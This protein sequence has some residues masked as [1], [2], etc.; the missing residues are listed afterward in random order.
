M[1]A[2]ARMGRRRLFLLLQQL[3]SAGSLLRA[4]D[5]SPERTRFSDDGARAASPTTVGQSPGHV[6]AN[7]LQVPGTPSGALSD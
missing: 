1:V 2:K 6:P 4:S 5:R 3:G 7:L